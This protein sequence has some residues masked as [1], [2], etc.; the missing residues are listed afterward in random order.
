VDLLLSFGVKIISRFDQDFEADDT[1]IK[2][3][4][5]FLNNNDNL[6]I[7]QGPFYFAESRFF[8]P[9]LSFEERKFQP[10]FFLIKKFVVSFIMHLIW[11][12][13]IRYFHN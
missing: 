4:I 11:L 5:D 1:Y 12:L 8:P 3:Y 2:I 10:N 7:I 9:F 13:I 6:F